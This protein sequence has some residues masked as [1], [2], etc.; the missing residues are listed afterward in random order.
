MPSDADTGFEYDLFATILERVRA[1]FDAA[2][3]GFARLARS[4]LYPFP[5]AI[6][7]VAYLLQGRLR[8]LA[9]QA[10]PRLAAEINVR[11]WGEL[12]NVPPIA[13]AYAAGDV[14]F[15]GASGTAIATGT[16]LSRADGVLYTVDAPGGTVGIG[17]TVDLPVT[18]S[19][20]GDDGNAAA[21]VELTVSTPVAGLVSTAVVAAGGLTGGL[22]EE[23]AEDQAERIE[24][25]MGTMPQGG[26]EADYHAWV[27]ASQTHVDQVAVTH[28]SDNIVYVWFTLEEGYALG[29]DVIPDA[30]QIA[31]VQDYIDDTDVYG[32]DARRPVTAAATVR[33]LTESSQAFTI[34]GVPAAYRTAVQAALHDVFARLQDPG[35]AYTIYREQM[36]AA[37]QSVLPLGDVADI[38]NPPGDVAATAGQIRTV[39][40]IAWA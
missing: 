38:T 13:E 18:A 7:G 28:P 22:D 11:R 33:T 25:R 15:T 20:V 29:G 24:D 17:G 36:I 1:D 12:V 16:E 32:H 8:W 2:G 10:F 26:A 5:Y 21:A 27:R 31:A 23:S 39:G 9:K 6:A 14:T 3:L 19:E 34:A 35:S 40:A 37:A 4:L 30:T